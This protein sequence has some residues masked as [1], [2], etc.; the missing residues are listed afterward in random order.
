MRAL[1]YFNMPL[2]GRAPGA[3]THRIDFRFAGGEDREPK[4]LV[5]QVVRVDPRP[6]VT[7][8]PPLRGGPWVAVYDPA[9]ARGH[10]R[11]VYA[12]DGKARIP[13]RFAIDFFGTDDRGRMTSDESQR[14][15]SYSGYAA[16]VLAVADG[17]VVTARDDMSEP[18]ATD[19]LPK[20]KLADE[21]GNYISLDL[22]GGRYAFYEHLQPGLLVRAGER[23][24]REQVI[25][26]VGLTGSGTKPHLH[27]HVADANSALGAEGVPF[28]VGG[29]KVL[30]SYETIS[31]AFE[32]KPWQPVTSP[33][34]PLGCSPAPNTVVEF[35]PN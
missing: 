15:V 35:D 24:R 11:V 4:Q 33:E 2:T 8:G 5:T 13:G 22:G 30:G 17:V 19:R 10:R 7:H 20:V 18:T 16:E 29:A 1:V 21:T 3:V 26:R 27:F 6:S 12:T 9:L 23:V 14:L 25:A 28:C 34:K 32:G 31:A